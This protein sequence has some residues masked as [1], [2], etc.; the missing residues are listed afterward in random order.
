[1]SH[2]HR[3]DNPYIVLL[4]FGVVFSRTKSCAAVVVFK[5]LKPCVI[6]INYSIHHE[7]D[8]SRS[9]ASDRTGQ[10]ATLK[11]EGAIF[12]LCGNLDFRGLLL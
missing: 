4:N 6:A 7:D 8:V 10:T 12:C 2:G 9:A 1:M 5:T 11:L 3:G